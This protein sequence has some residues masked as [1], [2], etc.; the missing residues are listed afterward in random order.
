MIFLKKTVK[1]TF[2]CYKNTVVFFCRNRRKI[3]EDTMVPV[4]ALLLSY[5]CEE[6]PAQDSSS[7]SHY[8]SVNNVDT[9]AASRESPTPAKQTDHC[10]YNT[11]QDD[12]ITH[13]HSPDE[14]TN[15]TGLA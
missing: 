8:K 12:V 9:Q 5:D 6:L 10:Q 3:E 4:D 15:S 11:Q 7:T 14:N 1:I 2:I 13:V